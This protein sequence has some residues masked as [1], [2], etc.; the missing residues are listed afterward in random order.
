M[1]IDTSPIALAPPDELFILD[2]DMWTAP[3]W[4]ACKA[5]RLTVAQCGNC[6]AYRIPPRPFCA[7]CTSQDIQWKEIGEGGEIYTFCIVNVAIVPAIRHSIPYVPAVV[8]LPEADGVRMISNIV[9]CPIGRIRIGAKAK[10]VWHD[11][12]D[13][14]SIP[15]FSVEDDPR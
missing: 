6:G 13:G 2:T 12:P 4:E 11:R 10:L 15:R 1:T 14:I 7:S 3:Y 9:G 5:H 8:S